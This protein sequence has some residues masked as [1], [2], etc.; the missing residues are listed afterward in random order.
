MS[1][2]SKHTSIAKELL[3][4]TELE[5]LKS[6][7]EHQVVN[8]GGVKIALPY[9][10]HISTASY[11]TPIPQE[12]W[13]SYEAVKELLMSDLP[14]DWVSFL[15]DVDRK[16]EF[17][18]CSEPIDLCH[19]LQYTLVENQDLV[20][21]LNIQLPDQS[22]GFPDFS[23]TK[24][25]VNA[26]NT[27]LSDERLRNHF[28]KECIYMTA[29]SRGYPMDTEDL[30]KA[31]KLSGFESGAIVD[32]AC[33]TG[34][35]TN[36]IQNGN[37]QIIGLDRQYRPKWYDS[38]WKNADKTRHFS[39]ADVRTLPLKDNSSVAIVFSAA[40]AYFNLESLSVVVKEVERV[41][42]P[43]GLFF[44]GPQYSDDYSEWTVYKKE[45]SGTQSALK[46]ISLD[47]L[48]EE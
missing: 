29:D 45:V 28:E 23:D 26:V 7:N 48:L 47:K 13:A 8:V 9:A 17:A 42:L 4:R 41:L 31:I 5:V 34:E 14:S 1:V 3:E 27:V 33:G 35:S 30:I 25:V 36:L 43:G 2:E 12:I 32:L 46:E 40:D 16:R 20:E 38:Q 21:E 22:S 19:A 39:M 10:L 15:Q 18:G 37:F 11:N 44:V 24:V 6:D